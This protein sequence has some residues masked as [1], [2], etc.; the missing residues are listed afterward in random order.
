MLGRLAD[1]FGVSVDY[2]L[3]REENHINIPPELEGVRVAFNDGLEGLTQDDI[4][5]VAK[6][7]AFLKDKRK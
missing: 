1:Y 2:L 4:D 7:I 6:Y 5:D 3:G